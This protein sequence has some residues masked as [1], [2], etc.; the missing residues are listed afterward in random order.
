MRRNKFV[1]Y[2]KI[3]GYLNKAVMHTLDRWRH[4]NY[5]FAVDSKQSPT[6]TKRTIVNVNGH[7]LGLSTLS[8]FVNN[9]S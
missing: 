8:Q 5:N 3:N 1:V 6:I 4:Y 7:Q 9:T 2:A